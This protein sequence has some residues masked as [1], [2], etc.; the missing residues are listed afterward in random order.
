M[1][2]LSTHVVPGV[3]WPHMGRGR[4]GRHARTAQL[5][6]LQ[7]QGDEREDSRSGQENHRDDET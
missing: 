5:R 4:L 6:V 7:R 3:I 1:E 2:G